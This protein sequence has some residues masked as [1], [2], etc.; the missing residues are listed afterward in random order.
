MKLSKRT[1]DILKYLNS[2]CPSLLI[3]EGNILRSR[4]LARTV[5]TKMQIEEEF[6]NEF[7]IYDISSLLRVLNLFDEPNVDFYDTHM[8]I[9]QGS[10][11]I[12]YMYSAKELFTMAPNN[13]DFVPSGTK[14]NMEVRL[15]QSEIANYLKAATVMNLD[16]ISF[17][18]D[19]VIL[20]DSKNKDA[21][22]FTVGYQNDRTFEGDYPESFAINFKTSEFNIYAGAYN[23]NFFCGKMTGVTMIS[24]DLNTTIWLGS[25]PS[26][27][28]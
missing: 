2:I 22:N 3:R 9:S 11:K 16:I 15:E 6:P 20:F 8:I 10:A 13:E 21:N 12:R 25:Q 14:W 27:S 1:I 17:T 26:S 24:E 7:L 23:A 28:V 18:K 19:A 5:L 4:N